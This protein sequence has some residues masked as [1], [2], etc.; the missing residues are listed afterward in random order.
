MFSHESEPDTRGFAGTDCCQE[1][2]QQGAA[3][4]GGR[5]CDT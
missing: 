2:E 3:P 5:G 4:F 1:T